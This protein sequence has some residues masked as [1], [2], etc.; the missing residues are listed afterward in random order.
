MVISSYWL[1]IEAYLYFPQC[2]DALLCYKNGVSYLQKTT[3]KGK[4]IFKLKMCMCVCVVLIEWYSTCINGTITHALAYLV[5]KALIFFIIILFMVINPLNSIYT[6]FH[7]HTHSHTHL[8]TYHTHT[9]I[10]TH[11]HMHTHTYVQTSVPSLCFPV[12]LTWSSISL[13]WGPPFCTS[14]ALSP[15][16]WRRG[17]PSFPPTSKRGRS[18]LSCLYW[19]EVKCMTK[20]RT[21]I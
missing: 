14:L 21:A 8:H 9:Y 7:T 12:W 5:W 2:R 1:S 20:I 17:T 4:D 19:W 15:P 10:H 6:H 18:T 11:T 3:S 16:S 13:W